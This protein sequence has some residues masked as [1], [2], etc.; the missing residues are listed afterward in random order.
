MLARTPHRLIPAPTP[1]AD[2][3]G[4]FLGL[5]DQIIADRMAMERPRSEMPDPRCACGAPGTLV[6]S[7]WKGLTFYCAACV[8]EEWRV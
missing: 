7:D 5:A 2:A 3:V 1:R 6:L 8:P 4:A